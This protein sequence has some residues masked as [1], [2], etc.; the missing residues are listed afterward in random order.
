MHKHFYHIGFS[1]EMLVI[2]SKSI[3][4][5]PHI[6]IH[7]LRSSWLSE[8]QTVQKGFFRLSP[9]SR[10]RL[11]IQC[12]TCLWH[13]DFSFSFNSTIVFFF[14]GFLKILL[15][16]CCAYLCKSMSFVGGCLLRSEGIEF[17]WIE[18][19][20]C[21]IVDKSPGNWTQVFWK[22]ELQ[23]LD[24][25]RYVCISLYDRLKTQNVTYTLGKVRKWSKWKLKIS[26]IWVKC[27][28]LKE[29]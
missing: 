22:S 11:N 19:I 26:F 12:K 24:T 23:V 2:I 28:H 25:L 6:C 5:D 29:W 14:K 20:S 27:K 7:K 21:V 9:W 8:Q 4:Q 3:S 10:F 16:M 1:H 13:S 17:S 18:M 15:F